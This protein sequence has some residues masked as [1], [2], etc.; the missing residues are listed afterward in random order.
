MLENEDHAKARGARVIAAVEGV[1]L[2][3]EAHHITNPEPGGA[4]AAAIMRRALDDAAIGVGDVGYVNAHGTGT[5]QNDVNESA[6]I[7]ACFGE[8]RPL[9]SSSKAQIGHTL[10]ASGALEAAI[11]ALAVA[12][13]VVPPTAGLVAPDPACDVDH[14]LTATPV[15]G[16]G[17]AVTNSF[18]FGGTGA[19]LAITAASRAS[20]SHDHSAEEVVVT[21]VAAVIPQGLVTGVSL[22]RLL[23]TEPDDRASDA[24]DPFVALDAQAT[25]RMDQPARL[26]TAVI[27]RALAEADRDATKALPR[28]E[29]AALSATAFGSVDGSVRFMKRVLARAQ[30]RRARRIFRTSCRRHP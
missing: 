29:V 17:A 7:R 8:A 19:T 21:G 26:S 12:R 27:G 3:S 25:R 14:V 30:V 6:G 24:I 16:L 15:P 10:G 9:V 2:G 22:A 1:A 28:S 23:S 20:A 18:G 11:T 4:T 5:P 13:E